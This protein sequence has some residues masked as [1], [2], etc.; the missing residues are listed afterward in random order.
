MIIYCL[1]V[2]RS[3]CQ[4]ICVSA[5]LSVCLSIFFPYICFL[6][7]LSVPRSVIKYIRLSVCLFVQLSIHQFICPSVHKC[8]L[9]HPSVQQLV[10]RPVSLFTLHTFI[11]LLPKWSLYEVPHFM[12][13]LAAL[14]ASI[15]P[16]GIN[17]QTYFDNT[18]MTE[19]I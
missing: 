1:S 19:T 7:Y 8:V 15:R 12:R 14:F 17:T 16:S 3:V 4:T 5:F 11:H 6:S 10:F 2:C 13:K 9:L 18:P